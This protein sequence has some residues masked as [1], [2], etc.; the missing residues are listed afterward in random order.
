M[1]GLA[2]FVMRGRWQALL[3]SL[4]GAGTILLAWLSASVIALV[5]LRRGHKEGAFL[6]AFAL[7]PAGYFLTLSGDLAPLSLLL[8]ATVL[9]MVL[10]WTVSLQLTLLAS[11]AVG[12]VTGYALLLFGTV[13]LENYAAQ[14]AKVFEDLQARLPEGQLVTPGIS[15]IAGL[16]GLMNALSCV[17]CLLLA[18][19]WQAA[20]YNP[21]GFREEFHGLRLAPQFSVGLVL[22]MLGLGFAGSEYRPWAMLFALPLSIAGLGY[23]HARAAQRKLRSGWLGIFYLLWLLIDLVKLVVAGVAI[24][25]SFIDLRSRWRR[26]GSGKDIQ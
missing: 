10:R 1:K 2:K 3:V 25:D 4:L 12:V 24:A 14:L 15:T 7:L 8:G 26:T 17:V 9:A 13:Q 6:L 19:Y 22:M 18:R 23:I 16:L 21:G 5:I 20:L 11:V